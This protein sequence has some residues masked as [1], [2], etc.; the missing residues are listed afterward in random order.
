MPETKT[1][2]TAGEAGNHEM[3]HSAQEPRAELLK[4]S[5]LIETSS[6]HQ[7]Y[8]SRQIQVQLV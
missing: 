4:K 6:R 7:N 5:L 8:E 2:W 3:Q 1:H